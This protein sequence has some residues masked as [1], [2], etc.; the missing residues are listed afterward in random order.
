MHTLPATPDLP[1]AP[2]ADAAPGAGNWHA[3][4][5]LLMREVMKHIGKT[6]EK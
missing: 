1:G 5:M 4:E 6:E 2:G 3:Q